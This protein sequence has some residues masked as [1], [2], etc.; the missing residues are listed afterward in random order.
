MPRLLFSIVLAL[1]LH[2]LPVHAQWT[3]STVVDGP[4]GLDDGISIDASGNLYVSHYE[5]TTVK[6]VTPDGTVTTFVTGLSRPNGST[7]GP[8]GTLYIMNA[9]GSRITRVLSDGTIDHTFA[10]GIQNPT[11]ATMNATG[12][13]LYVAQYQLS[14]IVRVPLANPSQRDFFVSGLPLNG[15]VGMGF[16]PDG[17]LLVGNFNDG[18]I[19][20]VTGNGSMSKLAT[21]PANLGFMTV[22]G[23]DIYATSFSTNRIYHIGMD[24]SITL[25]AGSTSAGSTDGPGLD[26]RFS[27][28]NG[29]AATASGDT[30]YVSEYNTQTVRIL[31]RPTVT[32][33]EPIAEMPGMSLYPNPFRT[34][35]T[36]PS[37]PLEATQIFDVRGRLIATL[38]P[39][40][41]AVSWE[42]MDSDGRSAGPGLYIVRQ[43]T[44][45]TPVMKIR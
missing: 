27:G 20:R 8:D 12:D 44:R 17:A 40:A 19:V 31:T 41:S 13:T 26:A 30:L 29:I 43:G 38:P 4:A 36:I 24:G 2:A 5:G 6:K 28:P 23:S 15:P 35:L 39:S 9:A 42:G 37:S 3:V 1:V 18:A 33:A 11:G 7:I 34:A 32:R 25:I 16:A 22:S 10:T 21:V 14:R 45:S